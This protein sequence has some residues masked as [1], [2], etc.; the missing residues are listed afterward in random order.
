MGRE[1][2]IGDSVF[3]ES[4][5]RIGDRVTLKNRA[6]ICEGVTIE[7]D[8]FIG[9]GVIFTNDRYPRS[10]GVTEANERYQTKKKGLT[11]TRVERGATIGAG[12]VILS[13][14]TIG[15]FASVGAGAVVTQDVLPGRVVIGN[16]ARDVGAVCK[17]GMPLR[18]EAICGSCGSRDTTSQSSP[19]QRITQY[20]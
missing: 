20:V 3:V 8:V 18:G 14:V 19:E 15:S 17:C 10:R 12:A 7:N 9:P 13:G 5:A 1:C 4:G 11:R 2:N 16:P 6:L